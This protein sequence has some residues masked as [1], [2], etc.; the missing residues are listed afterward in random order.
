MFEPLVYSSFKKIVWERLTI[1]V[2]SSEL[3]DDESWIMALLSNVEGSPW[4]EER[5]KPPFKYRESVHQDQ[6]SYEE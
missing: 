5:R 3:S 2:R 6:W 4:L 1:R